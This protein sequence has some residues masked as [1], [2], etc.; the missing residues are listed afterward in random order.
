MSISG[1][2]VAYRL[3]EAIFMIPQ[4]PLFLTAIQALGTIV[5]YPLV[6]FLSYLAFGLRNSA[7]GEVDT[8]GHKL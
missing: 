1:V 7:P 6:V 3:A 8:L 4:A 5:V 2:F